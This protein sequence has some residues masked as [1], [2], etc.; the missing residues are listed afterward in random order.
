MRITISDEEFKIRAC[1][2][3]Q[4]LKRDLMYARRYNPRTWQSYE[5]TCADAEI[6][7]D[8]FLEEATRIHFGPV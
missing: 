8:E 1:I 7:I 4:S 3:L 2:L 6:K 5:N